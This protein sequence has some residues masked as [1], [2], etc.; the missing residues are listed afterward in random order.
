LLGVV[1]LLADA[2]F[3]R[4]EYSILVRSDLKGYGIGWKLMQMMI[5]YARSVG[6]K[7][8]E[9][10]VL[11]ENTTMLRMCKHLGFAVSVDPDDMTVM[12][13]ALDL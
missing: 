12:Q 1:H 9:G 11:R 3:E 8:I 10:Q 4:G 6:L 13:V 7:A 5:E 2:N